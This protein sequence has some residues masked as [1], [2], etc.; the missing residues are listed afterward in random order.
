[1]FKFFIDKISGSTKKTDN[2]PWEEYGDETE[3]IEGPVKEPE[4]PYVNIH[5]TKAASLDEDA[6]FEFVQKFYLNPTREL[7]DDLD[8][9]DKMALLASLG[10][11]V[12]YT[13]ET[14]RRDESGGTNYEIEKIV[15]ELRGLIVSD[16]ELTL[17]ADEKTE[18]NDLNIKQKPNY[19]DIV[20]ISELSRKQDVFADLEH[21][22][23]AGY[24]IDYEQFFPQIEIR[25]IRLFSPDEQKLPNEEKRLIVEHN[26]ESFKK[27]LTNQKR[28]LAELYKKLEK[29]LEDS[30]DLSSEKTMDI[31]YASAK[32]AELNYGQIYRIER[33]AKEYER[34]Y[35]RVSEVSKQYP[36]DEKLFTALFDR[37]PVGHINIIRD[38]TSFYI[39]CHN[40]ED[41][42]VAHMG[43][44]AGE[45]ITDKQTARAD[46]SAGAAIYKLNLDGLGGCVMIEKSS[47]VMNEP[48]YEH[49]KQHLI[50][51]LFKDNVHPA[52]RNNVGLLSPEKQRLAILQVFRRQRRKLEDKAK[53]ELLSFFKDGTDWDYTYDSLIKRLQ[54]GGIY[55]YFNDW[56][57]ENE[58]SHILK[59]YKEEGV[60]DDMLSELTEKAFINE[61]QELLKETIRTITDYQEHSP[62]S[63]ISDDEVI[64]L[65]ISEPLYQWKKVLERDSQQSWNKRW[66]KRGSDN[67]KLKEARDLISEWIVEYEGTDRNQISEDF[68]NFLES[69]K[70]RGILKEGEQAQLFV[71]YLNWIAEKMSEM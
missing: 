6:Y 47:G 22:P 46:N 2:Q 27:R 17:S 53:S 29:A 69:L 42:T 37:P 25:K 45:D 68:N 62:D 57:T 15:N 64:R 7:V 52:A 58:G 51:R 44:P 34:R 16:G 41:Y 14:P 12:H 23:S 65:L 33:G 35:K 66:E 60:S 36:D 9:E 19:E 31:V 30:P 48:T 55:D 63:E 39:R 18:L 70:N 50:T 8:P 24:K 61:Y 13:Y 59:K 56:S 40:L 21:L 32:D 4:S 20:R 1:M 43:I 54:D 11:V 5:E 71:D 67:L 10:I 49:E 28:G 3:Y 38:A 26:L